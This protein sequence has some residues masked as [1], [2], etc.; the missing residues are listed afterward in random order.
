MVL[1]NLK[2]NLKDLSSVSS[3]HI[4]SDNLATIWNLSSGG[5]QSDL[6]FFEDYS[7]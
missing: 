1:E 2:A 7:S 3:I 6:V 4:W 5:V